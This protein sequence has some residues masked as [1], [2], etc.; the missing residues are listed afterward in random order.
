MKVST[1]LTAEVAF[2]YTALAVGGINREYPN[3]PQLVV[4]AEADLATNRAL[5]PA[6]YGCFDWHSAVHSHWLLV[7]MLRTELLDS[8]TST[9]VQAT[10]DQHLTPEN[11]A[12][13][14][15]YFTDAGHTGF[16]FPY[17]WAWVLRLWHETGITP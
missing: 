5:H 4:R 1:E 11:L 12:T 10:L 6:F 16:E 8:K 3:A 17:G 14:L 9:E 7:R 2:G 15:A 13:E